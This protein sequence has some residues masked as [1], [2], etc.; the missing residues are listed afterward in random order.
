MI[1]ILP[2]KF[3]IV[4]ENGAEKKDRSCKTNNII[5]KCK[6]EFWTD[7]REPRPIPLPVHILHEALLGT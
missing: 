2:H 6:N 1:F 4:E 5:L 7:Y 3:Y